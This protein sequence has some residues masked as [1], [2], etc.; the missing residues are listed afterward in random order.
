LRGLAHHI[1]LLVAGVDLHMN[2]EVGCSYRIGIVRSRRTD[3]DRGRGRG[4]GLDRHIV[5]LMERVHR[6]VDYVF[7]RH[8]VD[9]RHRSVGDHHSGR[10]EMRQAY[11][12]RIVH[13]R[14]RQDEVMGREEEACCSRVERWMYVAA[15]RR[16]A[17]ECGKRVV[18]LP[19]VVLALGK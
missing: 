14:G 18:L 7:D 11:F 12:C 2:L 5:D 10:W 15:V 16:M 9:A 3:P 8:C 17:Q 6:S 1:H 4:L 13:G 19:V